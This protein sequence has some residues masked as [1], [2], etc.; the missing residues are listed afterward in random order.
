MIRQADWSE[1]S[2]VVTFFT[3]DFGKISAVAKGVRRLKSSFEAAIDLLTQCRIVFIRKGTGSLD[4]LTEAQLLS[5]FSP[6][7]RDLSSLYGGYYV[8]ELLDGFIQVYDSHPHLYD[9]SLLT[10]NSLQHHGHVSRTILQFEL[11]V[12]REI[13]LLPTL[14]ECVVCGTSTQQGGPFVFW[15]SQ[16]G[17]LCRTCRQ[18]TYTSP[19]ISSE[20]LVLLQQLSSSSSN[21]AEE[22]SISPQQVWEMRSVIAP[23]ISHALGRRPKMSRYLSNK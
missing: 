13:G 1:S 12:L 4:I 9:A 3:R 11:V 8:A 6:N 5:R 15:V 20:S 2:R 16:G 22:L 17:F 21:K 14:E 18:E 23:A 7:Q 19:E 10:L